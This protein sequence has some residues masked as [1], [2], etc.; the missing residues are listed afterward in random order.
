MLIEFKVGNF[1]CFRDEVVLDLAPANQDKSLLGNIWRGHRYDV[2]K[3]AA[4]FGPNASGKTVL[5]DA[6]FVF[7]RFVVESATAMTQGDPIPGITP[8]RLE[9]RSLECPSSFEVLVELDGVGYRYRVEADRDRVWREQLKYQAAEEKSRWV[10][11]I[12]R[13]C[14]P[15]QARPEADLHPRLGPK[16]R[17][18]RIIEDTRDNGLLLSRAAERNVELVMPLFEWFNTMHHSFGAAGIQRDVRQIGRL[19]DEAMQ[20]ENLLQNINQLI[21]DADTGI[22]GLRPEDASA[23][24]SAELRV[25]IE[26]D[27]SL[28]V[29][30]IVGQFRHVLN[31]LAHKRNVNESPLATLRAEHGMADGERVL[32]NSDEESAGTL[33]YLVLAGQILRFCQTPGLMVVDELDASLH[34]QLAWRVIQMLHSPEFNRAGAQLL[35]S[36]HDVTLMDASLLRRDQIFLTQKYPNGESELV[37]LWDFEE[38]PRNNA[39]WAKNYLAGRFGGTPILGPKLA[40]IPQV[41]EPTTPAESSHRPRGASADG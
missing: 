6:L 26:L 11:L 39:P 9:P 33:R 8:F 5:L 38:M 2:L 19:A 17:R 35:F 24:Q 31:D 27:S 20:D 23:H 21:R 40:D 15:G 22:L 10:T 12:E 25:G 14:S 37:S 16:G 13:D 29:E 30:Q 36:T 3:S 18:E 34:P 7:R 41:K 1:K 28:D 4:L 32:F